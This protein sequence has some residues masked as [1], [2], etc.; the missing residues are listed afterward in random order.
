[1]DIT[2][3]HDK[4]FKKIFSRKEDA[5]DLLKGALKKEITEKID[6][7][8][9]E[10]D[11]SSYIGKELKETFSDLVY[12]CKYKGEG[13]TKV[14]ICILLEHKSY[15]PAY[16][17]IQLLK[18]LTGIWDSYLQ[19]GEK[20]PPVIPVIIYAGREKWKKQNLPEYFEGTDENLRP[21]IPSFDYVLLDIT[22][23]SDEEIEK[24]YNSFRVQMALRLMKKIFENIKKF[25][26][27]ALVFKG[28]DRLIA[29]EKDSE[30]LET[31]LLYLFSNV[32][33]K[34]NN[35][36]EIVQEIEQQTDKGGKMAMTIASV[37]QQQGLQQGLQKGL[38]QGLQKGKQQGFLEGKKEDVL[39][40]FNKAGFTP[41]QI[42]D[43]LELDLGFVEKT[44]KEGL[45]K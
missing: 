2:N 11:N 8:T 12:D 45:K 26:K 31:T 30:F 17:P 6:F 20:P 18:Y 41:K 28:V 7:S 33:I 37:I 39:K 23:Y 19:R 15:V 43:I 42:A 21:F 10:L 44:I 32:N 29:D 34:I 38:Q 36:E 1:M 27:F 13:K 3:S 14:K 4:Y 35:V 24:L 9:L 40:L 5:I 16:P 25:S 22:G